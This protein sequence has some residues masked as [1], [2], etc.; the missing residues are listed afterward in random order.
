M[1]IY[2]RLLLFRKMSD[3]LCLTRTIRHRRMSTIATATQET[4]NLFIPFV[5]CRPNVF[6]VAPT[7]YKCYK[8]VLCLLGTNPRTNAHDAT[9]STRIFN[10]MDPQKLMHQYQSINKAASSH[11]R[12]ATPEV[13]CGLAVSSLVVGKM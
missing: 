12:L 13:A 9:R 11:A 7:L 10:V 8:H 6:D 2:Y 1:T 3:K 4:N 5:Q